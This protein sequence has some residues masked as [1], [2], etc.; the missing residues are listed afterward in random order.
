MPRI[1]ILA[2]GGTIA[3]RWDPA[4]H[5]VVPQLSPDDLIGLT[6]GLTDLATFETEQIANVDS[7]NM[8][9]EVWIRL[10]HRIR[11][12]LADP[13]VAA[14]VVT[15]GTDTLEETAYFLDLTT[16]SLKPVVLVGA[17]RPPTLPDTD[18]LRNL[19]DAVRVA[20]SPEAAGK[21]A[22]VVMNGQINAA[23]DV[24]KTSTT[25]REA[26]Q[27][28]EFGSLG[29]ADLETVR[30]YR[31]PLRR[32]TLPLT[33]DK[34]GRV[35]IVM[36]YAGADGTLIDA[37]LRCHP[38][39]D[40]LVIAATGLGQV[41]AS[42][43][44]AIARARSLDIPVVISTRVYTGRVIPLYGSEGGVASLRSLG[45]VLADNLSPVKARVLLLVALQHTRD[46]QALQQ[47]FDW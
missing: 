28:L 25:E 1:V 37:L 39:V 24:T 16:E 17:Q 46:P 31:A 35:E 10:A 22:L 38:A 36:H 41:S 33:A 30:F 23:R 11:I 9:P 4:C 2:T 13:E 21:G 5:G 8:T 3:G 43:Y 7:S 26:F 6:P 12:R 45:C 29:V 44:E 18:A 27:S 15:H 40:G 32:R 14:A 47:F 34:L 20:L 42:M 19:T